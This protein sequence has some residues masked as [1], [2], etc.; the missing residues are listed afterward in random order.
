[1]I[2][3]DTNVLV[4]YLAQ[5]D[6]VQSRLASELIEGSLSVDKPG[7][8]AVVTLAEVV[9]VMESCYGASRAE[10]GD[11]IERMLRVRQLRFQD[12]DVAWQAL[13]AF[14]AGKADFADCLIERLGH[15]EGCERT[16]TF[17]QVAARGAGMQIL[18]R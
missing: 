9:W 13:R 10:V 7:F 12:S 11:I 18:G 8:V 2:G 3:L 6:R 17:D 14:R 15:A 16:V 5:D 4:R 1:M